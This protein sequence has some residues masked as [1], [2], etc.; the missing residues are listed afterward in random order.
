MAE[1]LPASNGARRGLRVQV[2]TKRPPR[3][4]WALLKVLELL[5]DIISILDG[6]KNLLSS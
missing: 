3:I 5:S 2:E 6:L 4:F 1:K